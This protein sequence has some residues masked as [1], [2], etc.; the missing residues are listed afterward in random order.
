MLEKDKVHPL[1]Q[2]ETLHS[3]SNGVACILTA[4]NK[5]RT[6]AISQDFFDRLS[7]QASQ[8]KP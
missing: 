1:S 5:T 7:Q 3:I 6:F 2:G 8:S 4:D